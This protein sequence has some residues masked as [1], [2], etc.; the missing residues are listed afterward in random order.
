MSRP[1]LPTRDFFVKIDSDADENLL[2]KILKTIP[3]LEDY[4]LET[5][6][7]YGTLYN[8]LKVVRNRN[9]TSFYFSIKYYWG[10]KTYFYGGF[11]EG[12][13]EG[14]RYYSKDCKLLFFDITPYKN[15]QLELDFG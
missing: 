8:K 4:G 2:I 11:M 5:K 13:E 15:P 12:D 1:E 7:K 10:G 9:E 3:L 14:Y 6:N